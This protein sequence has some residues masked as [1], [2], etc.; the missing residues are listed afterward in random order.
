MAAAQAACRLDASVRV[1]DDA[2]VHSGSATGWAHVFEQLSRGRF[3]GTHA[4]VW[5]GPLQ[6]CYE[7]VDGAFSYYGRAWR[8]ARVFF[9]LLPGSGDVYYDGRPIAT[10]TLM[11]HRWDAFERVTGSRRAEVLVVAVDESFFAQHVL[12]TVGR[13]LCEDD[14]GNT[15]LCAQADHLVK[16]FERSVVGTLRTVVSQ[17]GLLD[18]ER[19]VQALRQSVLGTLLDALLTRT[20]ADTRL[21]SSSTRTYIVNKAIEFVESRL[22]DPLSIADVCA[23]VRV[24]PRTLRYSFESVLGV[25]PAYYIRATRLN[26]VRRELAEHTR[27]SIQSIA[28]RWGFCHMGRFARYYRQVFGE[29]PSTTIQTANTQRRPPQRPVPPAIS[30]LACLPADL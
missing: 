1:T 2:W 15:A 13:A 16:A 17:P 26:R 21:P 10:Q 19:A 12:R 23:A 5:L 28:A 22:S 18:E 8:G 3:H 9:S 25:T 29:H 11:T 6:I 20:A 24:C 14:G 27:G 7:R 4:E 30:A